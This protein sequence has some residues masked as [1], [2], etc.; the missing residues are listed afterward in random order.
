MPKY[1]TQQE[2]ASI[3][4]FKHYRSLNHLVAEGK[5]ECVKRGGRNG[6]KLFAEIHLQ[7]YLQSI[8][9]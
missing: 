7:K 9:V 4:G 6:R 2:A 8:T 3:L 1:F 5:L